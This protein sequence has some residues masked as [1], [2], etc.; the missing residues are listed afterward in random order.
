MYVSLVIL[1]LEV[2]ED[3]S[4]PSLYYKAPLF[5][6]MSS[7][8]EL[9]TQEEQE[10]G[11][12]QRRDVECQTKEG[13][14][15]E[16]SL[17]P[18]EEQE[19]GN[20][21]KGGE[22]HGNTTDTENGNKNPKETETESLDDEEIESVMQAVEKTVE[23]TERREGSPSPSKHVQ[24]VRGLRSP[25]EVTIETYKPDKQKGDLEETELDLEVRLANI[26][27]THQSDVGEGEERPSSTRPKT[28]TGI[29][30]TSGNPCVEVT[31]GIMHLFKSSELTPCDD[32]IPRSEM[33]CILNT[34]CSMLTCDLLKF[35]S[36]VR[37]RVEYMRII[38]GSQP[39]HYM[40]LLKFHS[41]EYADEFYKNYN[42][43]NYSSL[44]ESVCH[45]LYVARVEAMK[46]EQGGYMPEA[47]MTELPIC[48]ICLERMD[49]SVDGILTV[50]CNH[51]FHMPC[52]EQWE[53]TTCPVCRYVQ[54]P[55]P[56]ADSKCFQCDSNES[57]WICLVC[58]HVGCGRYQQAHAYEHF[59]ESQHTFSMQLGNQRVWDYAGDN[60]VHRL[61]Q[62]KGD[63]KLVE[64]DCPGYNNGETD[65]KLDSMQLEYTYLLT[66]QLDS[67]R[68]YWEDKIARVEQ[69][70]I[71]EA[72]A[73]E[74]RF[75]KTLEKC[76][77]LEQKLSD[78]QKE[79][80]GQDKRCQ[81][82]LTRVTKLSKDLKEEKELNKC[83]SQNQ[84]QWQTRYDHLEA[85]M[86]AEM[87]AKSKEVNELRE[88]VRD[89]MFFLEAKQTL[90][91]VP[92]DQRQEIADGQ[93]VMGAAAAPP[94]TG[95]GHRARRGKKPR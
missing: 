75:K 63:G 33:I 70:A 64:W 76:E 5:E 24:N 9:A 1:R 56:V 74:A 68:R 59:K 93:I 60:W 80:Q 44:E 81:Q 95:R 77:E 46:A 20:H 54:C 94:G 42:G 83:L 6:T 37:D 12:S 43:M 18:E 79:R 31:K 51:S 4:L 36:P 58:G 45:L 11:A 91:E 39:N 41:Q 73:M 23:P 16:Q 69:N 10:E 21:G 25:T 55:E 71:E 8:Q 26:S 87:E 7:V 14:D 30:F 57:L 47:G 65:E 17:H 62:S 34:P 29:P 49:E 67:Q 2:V 66:N 22:D 40:V 15:E 48:H 92:E 19:Q 35:M 28:P 85:K 61:V 84:Q 32:E 90:S 27:V 52:L 89:L 72:S 78:A 53:D 86:T 13:P 38:R 50:L 88:Q 82:L 3:C